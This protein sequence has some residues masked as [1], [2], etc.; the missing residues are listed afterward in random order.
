MIIEPIDAMNVEELKRDMPA[1]AIDSMRSRGIERLT[2]PQED[3]IAHGLLSGKHMV[4]A[5]PTASGKTLIAEMAMLKAIMWKNKKAIYIAPMRAIVT[6]KFLDMKKDYPYIEAGI[7]IG[8][9]NSLDDGIS[10]NDALFVSTEKLDSLIRHGAE[11]I[12]EVGVFVFDEV[13]M[14]DDVSRGP[15]LEI[16]ISRLRTMN[17]DAQIIALS[18]TIGNPEEISEWL[19]AELVMSDYRPVPLQKGIV[20]EGRFLHDRKEYHLNGASKI[21]DTRTAEDT[22]EKKKQL[23][24]FYSSRRNAESGALRLASVT[25]THLDE[26][27]KAELERISEKILHAIDRPT[28]QCE[29]LA[30]LV[31]KGSA[32]HHSGL[33]NEQRAQVEEGFRRGVIKTICA[34]TTLGYGVNLPAHTVLVKDTSR[35]TGTEGMQKISTNEILQLFGRAGRP[36]YD[37]EG[38]ALIAAKDETEAEYVYSNYINAKPEP[39]ISK[40]GVLPVLRTHIL[41][42]IASDFLNRKERIL[43]FMSATFYGKQYSDKTGITEIVSEILAELEDW[44]FVSREGSEYKATKTG[45]K[46]S[47]LY[48][49]PVSAKWMIDSIPKI[50]DEVSGLF[51]L[52]NNIEMRPYSKVTDE[53]ELEIH[54]YYGMIKQHGD[55]SSYYDPERPFSTALMLR[56]WIS[57]KSEA[58]ILGKYGETPG[59]LYTKLSN[60]NWLAY[61]AMELAKL[62][63][64]RQSGILELRVRLRYDIKKELLDLV[65]LEQVG[66]VRARIMYNTGIRKVRDVEKPGSL[67]KLE[68]LFGKEIAEKIYG[69]VSETIPENSK[70]RDFPGNA[71]TRR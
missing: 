19:G 30:G 33:V 23:I 62:I 38:R 45:S 13:H 53:A 12:G 51:M 59:S 71:E 67:Q 39:V 28:A 41:A 6:E 15:T 14:I 11:W 66:R 21:A 20:V 54:K 1:E 69:Q 40:L 25:E 37:K 16:L 50:D 18:A 57:E 10:R 46:I 7:S 47:E 64:E 8:D 44:G 4:V 26:N 17:P 27:E 29:K 48:I 68:R 24:V 5:A 70:G 31:K 36:R 35:Y 52:T 56:D 42:F 60:A 3:A 63:K 58:E 65:R 2:P 61:A 49:D 22:L 34:T 55:M 32:F 9:L 43:D